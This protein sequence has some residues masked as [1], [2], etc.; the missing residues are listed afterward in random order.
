MQKFKYSKVC[1]VLSFCD[2]K[3][4][5]PHIKF[6]QLHAL[7]TCHAQRDFGMNSLKAAGHF[8]LESLVLLFYVLF[9]KVKEKAFLMLKN[10]ANFNFRPS[11]RLQ[12]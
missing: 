10:S 11:F 3:P 4:L 5:Y 6:K 1:S 2:I 8:N 9:K 12:K 7:L